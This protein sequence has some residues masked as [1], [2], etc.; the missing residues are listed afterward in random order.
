MAKLTSFSHGAG[1]ACK[2]GLSDLRDVL[3]LLGPPDT[4]DDV[5]IG[6]DEADDAAVVRLDGDD[7]LIL[8]I[9]FFTPLV[10]DAY[11]WGRIAAA[12]AS[13]DVY[14]MGG[15]PLV[16][17]NVTA[18][19]RDALP[20]ELLAD[21]LR[22]G[23]DIARRGGFHVVGGH[24]I[25]DPEPKYGMVVVG[26]ADATKLM[27]IDAA[28]PGDVLVL[29]KPIG[30]GI[31]TTAIKRD[32]APSGAA[33]AAIAS[34]T[35]LSDTASKVLVDAGV[36]ACTDV[37]GFGLMGHL[38]RMLAASGVG[39]EIDAAAVPLI[40]GAR[41]LADDGCIPGGTKRNRDAVDAF[42]D[43]NDTDET[44]RTLLCDAQTS[45]GLLAAISPDEAPRVV[46]ALSGELASAVIGR[47]T[48]DRR[49][50]VS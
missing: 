40:D 22:G 9:D 16:A 29:T 28:K 19:P 27:T 21:V 10:D 34:M 17:L 25:D 46:E 36:R 20:L 41:A 1:C 32:I 15:R 44:T 26:R 14:A 11:T 18:W 33:D 39:A 23:R 31:I 8:T 12:N 43:W 3:E 47:I 38:Q 37:T 24:T 50:V 35:H 7:A 48:E 13:S 45:G 5:L 6:L 4:S 30:T 42:I 49:I 2:L